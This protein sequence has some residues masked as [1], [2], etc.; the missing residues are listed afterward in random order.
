M[1]EYT[2]ALQPAEIDP[3]KKKCQKLNYFEN[4]EHRRLTGQLA[5]LAENTRPD[6]SN[7]QSKL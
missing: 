2:R 7:V 4:K 5:W 6:T 1:E 3:K